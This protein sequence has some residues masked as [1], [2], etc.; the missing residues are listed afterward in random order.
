VDA[1][2]CKWSGLD[3]DVRNLKAFRQVYPRG[4]NFLVV[5]HGS[6]DHALRVEGLELW[7]V[8]PTDL[9]ARA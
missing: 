8:S 9:I 3:P 6:P 2:E 7:L 4:K 1:Y 5:P